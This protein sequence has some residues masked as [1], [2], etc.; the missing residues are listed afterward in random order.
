MVLVG[1]CTKSNFSAMTVIITFVTIPKFNGRKLR[2]IA[3]DDA[4][5][6]GS[7]D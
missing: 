5:S 1:F 3:L 4:A 7:V 2:I 6:F